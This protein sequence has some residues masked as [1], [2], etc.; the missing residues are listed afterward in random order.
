MMK[1]TFKKQGNSYIKSL[2]QFQGLRIEDIV[3]REQSEVRLSSKGPAIKKSKSE[4]V[5]YV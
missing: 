5:K 3:N 4:W 2:L 1:N